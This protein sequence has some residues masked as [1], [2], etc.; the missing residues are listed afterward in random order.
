MQNCSLAPCYELMIKVHPGVQ[1]LLKNDIY[2][3]AT[4]VI[5]KPKPGFIG[6]LDPGS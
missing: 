1:S 6:V 3:H 5:S 4:P 2:K